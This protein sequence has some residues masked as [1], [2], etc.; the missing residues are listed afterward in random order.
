M[1]TI[2]TLSKVKFKSGPMANSLKSQR[3]NED[4]K[5]N[6]TPGP[7]YDVNDKYTNSGFNAYSGYVA[8]ARPKVTRG[9]IVRVFPGQVPTTQ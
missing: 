3:F 8:M 2:E 6:Q 9:S 7:K 5:L 1:T 4:S